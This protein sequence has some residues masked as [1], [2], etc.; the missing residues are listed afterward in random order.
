VKWVLDEKKLPKS[1]RPCVTGGFFGSKTYCLE[2][3]HLHWGSRPGWGSEHRMDEQDYE[4]ELHM[5]HYKYEFDDL[6]HAIANGSGDALAVLAFMH[7]NDR[8][9]RDK[10]MEVRAWSLLVTK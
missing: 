3:F 6:T 4:A 7:R 10:F 1:K 2:Q 9:G 8:K 5:V